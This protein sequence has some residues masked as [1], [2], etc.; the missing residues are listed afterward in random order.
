[1]DRSWYRGGW[2]PS[3]SGGR[4][5]AAS[6][7]L[8]HV[9]MSGKCARRVGRRNA[10]RSGPMCWTEMFVMVATISRPETGSRDREPGST[11]CR[12]PKSGPGWYPSRWIGSERRCFK[13]TVI[14][15]ENSQTPRT[16]RRIG[17]SLLDRLVSRGR[18]LRV[19]CQR[20]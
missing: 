17:A 16:V 20:R 15:S 12:H 2:P 4:K 5:P 1:M 14:Y 13:P 18:L 9:R 11:R 8:F 10:S 19:S 6:L 7:I 3:P